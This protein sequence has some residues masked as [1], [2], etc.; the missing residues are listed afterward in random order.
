MPRETV[1]IEIDA[2][3]E[4]AFDLIHDY[5]RRLSWDSM[6]RR[7]ELCDG[8]TEAGP[9]VRSICA[10][11]WRTG[12]IAMESVYLS[13]QRGKVAAVEM[14]NQAPFFKTFA[15]SI[16]HNPLGPQR[17]QVIYTYNFRAR[18][19]WLAWLLEPIM[20]IFLQYEVKKR[21]Q[22]LKSALKEGTP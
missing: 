22:M 5:R 21:L 8:A 9:G 7:A 15:A 1:C 11:K 2:S 12:G 17:S 16:R 10:G 14:C 13:F 19:R 18:P 4:A 20:N 3:C 6:L